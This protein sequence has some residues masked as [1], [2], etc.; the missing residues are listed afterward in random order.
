MIGLCCVSMPAL[1]KMLG[2][3]LPP[4][5]KVKTWII[6]RF[7]SVRRKSS[8][9]Y[10]GKPLKLGRLFSS[11]NNKTPNTS[12]DSYVDLE[13]N[14]LGRPDVDHLTPPYGQ[15]SVKESVQTFI[16]SGEK[17]SVDDDAIHFE[18][19][20]KQHSQKHNSR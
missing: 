14:G 20:M 15:G 2:H 17:K 3:H 4:C 5:V 9:S 6:S 7:S 10:A 12:R 8:N 19:E 13:R 11:N 1:P 18:I 16:K